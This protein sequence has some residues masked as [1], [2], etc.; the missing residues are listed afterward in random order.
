M[1]DIIKLLPDSVAN[2]IAAGEVI[3]RPAS[4]VKEMLE[5]S[6]DAK[7]SNIKLIIKDAG[8][9]LIQ[10]VDDGIG[11]SETD[12]RMCFERHAT[13]K[14]TNADDLFSIKTLGFRGE[15][16]ASIA[17]IARVELKSKREDDQLGTEIIVEG[18]VVESQMPCQCSKGTSISVKNLFYNTPARR[19]FLKSDSIE[20]GNIFNEFLRVSLAY[21][22]IGFSYYHNNELVQQLEAG[23]LKQRISGIFGSNYNQRLVPIEES[24]QIVKVYGFIGKPEF[25]KKKRGE[26]FFFTNKRFIKSAYLNHAIEQAYKDLI[27]E[28][29]HPSFFIFLDIN[30][31]MID[32]NVHPT[33]TEIKFQDERFIYQI[34]YASA[35]RALG[36]HNITPTLDFERETAFDDIVI[37]KTKEI[38]PPQINVNPDYNPFDNPIGKPSNVSGKNLTKH[39]SHE[40]W[41][42]IFSDSKT[43]FSNITQVEQSELSFQNFEKT[44][45]EN[46]EKYSGSKFLQIQARFIVSP[47]K[48]GMMIIDQ[49][50]AHERILFE[51]YL[52]CTSTGKIS[53][54]TLLF[55]EQVKL[56][57][58]DAEL[59]R[60]IMAE[61]TAIGF[62]ISEFSKNTFV[63]NAVP[64]DIPENQNTAEL[65]ETLLENYKRNQSDLTID[66]HTNLCRSIAKKLSVKHGKYLTEVE[67]NA[68]VDNLF[69]CQVPNMSPSGK[70][71]LTIVTTDELIERF[72]S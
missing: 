27:S 47:V 54:Q 16:L 59:I 36:Q 10:V 43:S 69:A 53:S 1:S 42:Q 19:N 28:G 18:S 31:D 32:V 8:K 37:D 60:E 20:K 23:N 24:T 41:E 26:Q 13:S 57:E 56:I 34:L 65:V 21:P 44:N 72:K 66:V 33:K 17:S 3:Q 45:I 35:K 50:L 9:T 58:S 55:P 64:A 49:Q 63:V 2:Q 62:E 6:I 15:A 25:S 61:I 46:S 30:A 68:L 40:K 22:E 39:V 14:I 38:R 48:S 7:A 29:L 71:I 51:K 67:M 52:K 70:N 12:A 5:N 11:M 4:A